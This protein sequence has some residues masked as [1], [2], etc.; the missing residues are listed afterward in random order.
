MGTFPL[1]LAF[2]TQQSN[3]ATCIKHAPYSLKAPT[4]AGANCASRPLCVQDRNERK[5]LAAVSHSV[6]KKICFPT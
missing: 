5:Q 3:S 6:N 2:S 4:F 1:L